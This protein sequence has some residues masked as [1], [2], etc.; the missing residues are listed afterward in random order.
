MTDDSLDSMLD[1][2]GNVAREY[3]RHF[4]NTRN[5]EIRE[6]D[7]FGVEFR[8]R[9]N[10]D[11]LA[12]FALAEEK[13]QGTSIALEGEDCINTFGYVALNATLDATGETYSLRYRADRSLRQVQVTGLSSRGKESEWVNVEQLTERNITK[14]LED[15]LGTA[16]QK[17]RRQ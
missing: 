12:A 7:T 5:H 17:L 16:V 15:F 14:R 1:R 13:M 4:E 11:L 10:E 6:E 3:A 2:I 8:R 9:A